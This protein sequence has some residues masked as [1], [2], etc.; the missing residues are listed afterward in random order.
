MKLKLKKIVKSIASKA[1]KA[2]FDLAIISNK[3]RNEAIINASQSLLKNKKDILFE[4]NK[5][6]KLAKKKKLNKALLD[7]LFLDD[8]R[9]ESMCKGMISISK[10]LFLR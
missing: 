9:I 3:Q 8:S 1:K 6:M 5:D 2:S 7:R 10:I 4:N